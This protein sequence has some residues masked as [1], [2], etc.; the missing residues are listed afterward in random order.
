MEEDAIASEEKQSAA[1]TAAT[2]TPFQEII[3]SPESSNGTTAITA[4]SLTESLLAYGTMEGEINL[5]H[6][7]VKKAECSRACMTTSAT[8]SSDD[9]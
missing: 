6:L 3:F 1:V 5:F 8:T 7:Q 9:D 4:I 2:A